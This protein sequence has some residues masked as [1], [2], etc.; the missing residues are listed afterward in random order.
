MSVCNDL[1]FLVFYRDP[2]VNG[3]YALYFINC[4]TTHTSSRWME[5]NGEDVRA[6]VRQAQFQDS[7]YVVKVMIAHM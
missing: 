4:P 2:E 6:K 3:T 1:S 5:D 7:T